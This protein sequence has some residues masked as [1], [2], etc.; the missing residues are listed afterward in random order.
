M[1][2]SPAKPISGFDRSA[3]MNVHPGLTPE[4]IKSHVQTFKA[5]GVTGIIIG[6]GGH[7]YIYDTLS[8]LEKQIEVTKLLVEECHQNGIKVAEHHSNVLITDKA[9]MEAH[10][11]WLMYSLDTPTQ[12]AIWDGYATWAFCPNNPGFRKYYWNLLSDFI[13]RTGVDVVMSDDA[14]FYCGCS[15]PACQAR[16]Q[17]ENGTDL[18]KAYQQSKAAGS[19]SWRQWHETRRQWLLD[20]RKWL[21]GKMKKEFPGKENICL[22]NSSHAAWPTLVHGFYPEA[23][24]ETAE[25]VCWEVYNPADFYSWQ[26]IGVEAAI[27]HEASRLRNVAV[28]CLPFADQAE[29]LNQYDPQEE[30]FM[31]AVTKA[32][33]LNF[34]HS[35]VYLNGMVPQ[36]PPRKYFNFEKDYLSPY[37]EARITSPLGIMYSRRSRDTDPRWEGNH[38]IPSVAWGEMCLSNALPFRAVTEETLA[39][40]ELGETQILVLPNVFAL[41]DKNLKTVESFVKKGGTLVATYYTGTHDENGKLIYSKRKKDLENLYGVQLK[42]EQL[43]DKLTTDSVACKPLTAKPFMLDKNITGFENNY[44][45]GKVYYFPTLLGID[46]HQG[47]QR[48]GDAYAEPKNQ[49]QMETLSKWLQSLVPNPLVKFT[50][51]TPGK[52]P[53]ITTQ[54]SK[55]GELLIQMVNTLGT[56]LPEGTKI[57]VP[58][59][60]DWAKPQEITLTFQKAPKTIK[61]ISYTGKEEVVL[62]NHKKT[63]LLKTPEVYQLLAVNF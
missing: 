53:L 49:K 28:L 32:F 61:I 5:N 10:K 20:F 1:N 17:K 33:G 34:C 29:T 11:D 46:F 14:C 52:S 63:V 37:Q 59:K 58:S 26:K 3:F 60:V 21:Y 57:P 42:C 35:R 13:K 44:G 62:K 7:H 56:Y 48:E 19:D 47:Y 54:T 6:G 18:L 22:S 36:D 24:L 45:K 25:A 15:C 2:L 30:D 8:Q 43:T 40:K 12:P 23:G 31:W 55:K 50:V 41:S 51:Q 38:V 9:F 39:K 27:F 16:W 4:E